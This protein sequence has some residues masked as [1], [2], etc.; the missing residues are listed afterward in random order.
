M[1]CGCKNKQVQQQPS[2]VKTEGIVKK[3]R[4]IGNGVRGLRTEKRIIR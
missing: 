4:P 2:S 1:G 3:A